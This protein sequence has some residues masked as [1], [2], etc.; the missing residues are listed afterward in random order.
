MSSLGPE[1]GQALSWPWSQ[2]A[3]GARDLRRLPWTCPSPR[4]RH[5]WLENPII[6]PKPPFR[7]QRVCRPRSIVTLIPD[8]RGS[9]ARL[10]VLT[11]MLLP[12]KTK[13][14]DAR[15]CGALLVQSEAHFPSPSLFHLYCTSSC[16]LERAGW[17]WSRPKS[18]SAGS[19]ESGT[20]STSVLHLR[21][22]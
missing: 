5:G 17:G 10:D 7:L 14:S 16:T 12:D 15:R 8:P 22:T 3:F 18:V 19:L 4:L 21:S 20:P 2:Y 9:R 6:I 13:S 11:A 1:H